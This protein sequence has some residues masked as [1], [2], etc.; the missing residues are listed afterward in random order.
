MVCN[1]SSEADE[2]VIDDEDRFANILPYIDNAQGTAELRYPF[3]KYD[4]EAVPRKRNYTLPCGNSRK[5]HARGQH[6]TEQGVDEGFDCPNEGCMAFDLTELGNLE[7]EGDVI[8]AGHV[9]VAV[10]V[11]DTAGDITIDSGLARGVV[12]VPA[13]VLS[14][15]DIPPDISVAVV[16]GAP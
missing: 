12:D 1:R 6:L 8:I 16:G 9:N 7:T 15:V 5:R 11:V 13:A 14:A 3:Y 2:F 4:I 10:R